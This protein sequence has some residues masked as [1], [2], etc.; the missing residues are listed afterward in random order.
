MARRLTTNQ[1]ILGSIPSVIISFANSTDIFCLLFAIAILNCVLSVI[2][3]V[4]LLII[5]VS[6]SAHFKTN[7]LAHLHPCVSYLDVRDLYH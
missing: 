4:T 2:D 5:F 3:V 1:K 7:N 6:S